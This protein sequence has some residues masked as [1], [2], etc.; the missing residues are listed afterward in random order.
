M[1]SEFV[2]ALSDGRVFVDYGPT[3]MVITARCQGK[4]VP[5]LA[6]EAFPLIQDGLQ[7][8]AHALP[9]LRQY[10]SDGAFSQLEGLPRVMAESVLAT[11]EKTLTP[12]AAVAGTVADMVADWIFARGADLV[13]V[14]NGG[15]VAVRLAPGQEMRMGILPDPNGGDLSQVITLRAEDGIGG[16]CTSGLG[17]RSL[18]RGIA[19]SVTVFSHRCAL[20]DACATHIANCS[21]VESPRV[22]TCLAGELDPQSD[23]ADLRV[24][25]QVEP[26]EEAELLQGMEQVRLESERQMQKGNLLYAAADIQNRQLWIPQ[27]LNGMAEHTQDLSKNDQ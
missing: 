11:G 9:V 12:M 17:G 19:S 20:A 13:A 18:T 4:P 27:P 23:I 3:T 15:D 21:Y 1:I 25:R 5:E 8:I 26:L 22:H 7:E 24:V 16:V 14:N 6:A 2:H 10:P